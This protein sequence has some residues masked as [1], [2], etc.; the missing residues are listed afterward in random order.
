MYVRSLHFRN[1]SRD[2]CISNLSFCKRS[3]LSTDSHYVRLLAFWL[4]WTAAVSLLTYHYN[5][6]KLADEV[7]SMW[8]PIMQTIRQARQY[9][10][11]DLSEWTKDQQQ[12]VENTVT[13]IGQMLE[14]VSDQFICGIE[15]LFLLQSFANFKRFAVTVFLSWGVWVTSYIYKYW[16]EHKMKRCCNTWFTDRVWNAQ[17]VSVLTCAASVSWNLHGTLVYCRRKQS[18]LT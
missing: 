5:F 3:C 18:T 15:A 7:T 16:A 13:D 1:R 2:V 17:L 4:N 12:E 14:V 10:D 6:Q 11:D 8:N 9:L